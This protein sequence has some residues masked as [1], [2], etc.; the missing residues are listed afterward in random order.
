MSLESLKEGWTDLSYQ[1]QSCSLVPLLMLWQLI[2]KHRLDF[3]YDFKR[4]KTDIQIGVPLKRRRRQQLTSTNSHKLNTHIHVLLLPVH[5]PCKQCHSIRMLQCTTK[6]LFPTA[7]VWVP[8][9]AEWTLLYLWWF[10]NIS[11]CKGNMNP[12]LRHHC[13]MNH[14]NT[15]FKFLRSFLRFYYSLLT[16]SQ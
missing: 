4:W 1:G 7:W 3:R 12:H 6:N 5:S 13:H 2:W 11:A 9:A 16:S 10:L 14:S 15:S 8:V